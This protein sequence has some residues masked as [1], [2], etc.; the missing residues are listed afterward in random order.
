MNDY[1][2]FAKNLKGSSL[3]AEEDL[4]LGV[5]E[6]ICARMAADGVTRGELARRLG[7]SRQNVTHILRGRHVST[8]TIARVAHALGCVPRFDLITEVDKKHPE[9]L[10]VFGLPSPTGGVGWASTT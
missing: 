8:R 7:C 6:A 1:R 3:E 2:Q 5:T 9:S 4:I 10:D